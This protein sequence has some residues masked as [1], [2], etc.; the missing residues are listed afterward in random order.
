MRQSEQTILY[1]EDAAC[2]AQIKKSYIKSDITEYIPPEFFSYT[3]ELEK[4]KK[5]K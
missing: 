3:Q 1:K 5:L 2:V 4:T